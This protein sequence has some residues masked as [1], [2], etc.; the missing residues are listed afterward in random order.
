MK[1][2][3]IVQKPMKKISFSKDMKIYKSN[4]AIQFKMKENP[5]RKRKE[6]VF[7]VSHH[8]DQLNFPNYM[9]VTNSQSRNLQSLAQHNYQMNLFKNQ[10]YPAKNCYLPK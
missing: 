2:E 3:V 9:M 10:H 7:K 5:M 1:P 4:D 8:F 6:E